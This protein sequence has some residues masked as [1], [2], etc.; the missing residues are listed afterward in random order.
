MSRRIKLSKTSS[1]HYFKLVFRSL[2]FL[3]ALYTFIRYPLLQT[4]TLK[5]A[6]PKYMPI[7][8]FV[9]IVFLIE[10]VLRMIPSSIESM[11]CQ[12]QFAVNYLP[13]KSA[14]GKLK[15][16]DK[17]IT[18][19][20]LSW[21]GLNSIIGVL[22]FTHLIGDGALFIIALAYSVSDMICILFFCPFQTWIM[23]NRCCTTCRIYNWDYFMMFTPLIFIKSFYTWSLAAISLILLIRWE[24]TAYRHPE[25]FSEEYN[26]NLRCINCQEK[27]K[28]QD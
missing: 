10:M 6:G 18:L 7:L 12:K 15:Y 14:K 22:Y 8:S 21:I 20:A 26:M 16:W 19:T 23:K 5:S 13:D 25:R 17:S 2:L 3:W 4:A 9:Y 24:I 1:M 11:G 27:Y 28:L